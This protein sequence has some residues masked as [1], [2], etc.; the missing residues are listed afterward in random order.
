[1]EE[2]QSS[3]IVYPNPF[4]AWACSPLIVPKPGPSHW[5]FSADLKPVN[6]FTVPFQYP[7]PV[8]EHELTNT[9]KSKFFANVDFTHSYWQL[10]LHEDS[11]ECQSIITPDGIYSS[12]RVLHGTTNAVLYLQSFL[13]P[14]LPPTLRDRVLLLVD[15][16]L[17]HEE[18]I[19]NLLHSIRSFL[20]FCVECNWLLNPCKCNFFLHEA[21]WCGRLISQSGIRHDPRNLNGPLEMDCP[22]T[23]GQLQQFL[24]AMQWVRSAIPRFQALVQELHDFLERVYSHMCKRTKRAVA[25]VSLDR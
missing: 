5:R 1:M 10:R 2:L 21:K 8:V 25:R 16:W 9:C 4:S 17:F 6:H 22:V 12:T 7:I 19:E 20:A 13:A 14:H 18:T 3:G 11:Q 24:C 23:G 15:D